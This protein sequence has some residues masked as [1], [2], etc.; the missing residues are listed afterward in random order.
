MVTV[1]ELLSIDNSDPATAIRGDY[2]VSTVLEI[3]I[4]LNFFVDCYCVCSMMRVVST[5]MLPGGKV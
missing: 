2:F 1:C 3:R 5:V 4:E